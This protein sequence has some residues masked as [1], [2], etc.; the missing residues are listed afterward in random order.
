MSWRRFFSDDSTTKEERIGGMFDTRKEQRE[1]EVVFQVCFA[2][3]VLVSLV[4]LPC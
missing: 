1:R 2:S 3:D 4:S